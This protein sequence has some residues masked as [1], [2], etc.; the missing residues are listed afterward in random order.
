MNVQAALL[1]A[2]VTGLLGEVSTHKP[3]IPGDI[4]IQPKDSCTYELSV[5][6]LT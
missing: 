3:N 6:K 1:I 4:A 2:L 5:A